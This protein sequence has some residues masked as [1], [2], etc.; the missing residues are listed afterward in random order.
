MTGSASGLSWWRCFAALFWIAACTTAPS[1]QGVRLEVRGAVETVYRWS[2]QQCDRMQI[3]DSPARAVRLRDG[4]LLLMAAHLTNISLV[5][6]DFHSLAPDCASHSQGREDPDPAAHDDRFW[7]QAIAPMPDGRLLGLASHEYMGGRHAGQCEHPTS[8]GWGCW[9]SSIIATVAESPH[10]RFRPLPIET[11]VVATSP[12]PF[13]RA[14]RRPTGFFTTSNIVFSDG[15]AHVLVHRRGIAG[16]PDGNCLL[17]ADPGDLAAGWRVLAAG[18]FGGSLAPAPGPAAPVACD[19]LGANVLQG[20]VRSVIRAGPDGPWVAV[21]VGRTRMGGEA[22]PVH[23]VLY[24]TSANL[25]DWSAPEML[26]R[27]DSF[28]GQPEGGVYYQYPSLIDHLSPSAVFDTTG[29]DLHLYLTRFNLQDRRQG[30]D[31]DLVRMPV[32]MSRLP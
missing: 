32:S 19:V 16:Q 1:A 20:P 2:T 10:Y 9:Y 15:F 18:G 28:T 24:S 23:G 22:A 27:M 21:M 13:D 5:G 7:I 31:R 11:R 4:R 30:M 12:L 29:G 6:R 3:P 14:M 17:R 25:R 8:A 26:W